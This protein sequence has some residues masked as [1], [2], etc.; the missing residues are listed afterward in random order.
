MEKYKE[1]A[2]VDQAPDSFQEALLHLLQDRGKL[3]EPEAQFY[4][5]CLAMALQHLHSL[6]IAYRD[7]KAENVLLTGGIFCEAGWPVLADFGLATFVKKEDAMYT[8]CG[9]PN[10]MAPDIALNLGYGPVVDWWSLGILV[11]Q[12]LTLSTPFEGRTPHVTL[13]N[14]KRNRRTMGTPLTKYGLSENAASFI[15]ELLQ[16]DPANRLGGS[17]FGGREEVRVHPF[18][19]GL[20]AICTQFEPRL[21][22]VY[23]AAPLAL[24]LMPHAVHALVCAQRLGQAREARADDASRR[25]VPC[26]RR[27]RDE[28]PIAPAAKADLTP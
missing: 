7:L 9:T 28:P 13:E 15:E 12:C 17:S 11:C 21:D 24:P 18:F 3:S 23:C 4:A 20:Y 16:P 2:S 10:F 8:F 1:L 5:A 22:G 25:P 14:V 19:W 27:C 26:A 6:G